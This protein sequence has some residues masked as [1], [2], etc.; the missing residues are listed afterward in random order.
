MRS[1]IAQQTRESED[2][3]LAPVYGTETHTSLCILFFYGTLRFVL[4]DSRQNDV[5]SPGPNRAVS[6]FEAIEA[7]IWKPQIAS[8]VPIVRIASKIF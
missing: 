8:I 5:V 7:I 4:H 3:A 6:V 2:E 1:K